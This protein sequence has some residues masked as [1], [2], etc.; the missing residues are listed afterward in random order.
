MRG[1][2]YCSLSTFLNILNRKQIYLS[3]P[4]KMNDA[5]EIKW[6]LEKIKNNTPP[7]RSGTPIDIDFFIKEEYNNIMD[8]LDADGQNSIY[9]SCFS[10]KSDI[11]SQWRAYA[12]DGKGVSIG[13]QLDKLNS[14]ENLLEE[15]II[16]LNDK[17]MNQMIDN[18]QTLYDPIVSLI[19]ND[20]KS[21]KYVNKQELV[22]K[23]L[24][25]LIP[26]LAK[27]KNPAF[28][29]EQEVRL[30][31]CR[32]MEIEKRL[33][34]YNQK[35]EEKLNILELDHEYRITGDNKITEFIKLDF[36]P[37]SIKHI[38]IGP[39]CSMEVNDLMRIVNELLNIDIKVTRSKASYR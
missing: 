29:E 5:L 35:K 20:S 6:C 21:D 39:K 34:R 3:D 22:K 33:Y 32:S 14:A 24:H 30:I 27:Y 38:C 26:V 36:N 8:I 17:S 4:L 9:I 18:L 13:F 16:Y 19:A 10:K 2:Y 15:E 12:D 25:E 23:V 1:Y 31:Y 28:R 37:K 11:L 7:S